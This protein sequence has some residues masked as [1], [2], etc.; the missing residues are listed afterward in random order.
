M[1]SAFC[2][3]DD[4]DWM[5]IERWLY[6]TPFGLRVVPVVKQ[7]LAASRSSNVGPLAH[8]GL[9]VQQLRVAHDLLLATLEQRPIP[10]PLIT[11]VS[12]VSS[13]GSGSANAGAS[14]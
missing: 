4:I 9:P 2:V 12:T 1:R 6:A 14:D 5:R 11:T 3:A 10:A 8:L 7:M 13:A